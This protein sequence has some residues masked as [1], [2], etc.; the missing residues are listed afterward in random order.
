ML[1]SNHPK[2]PADVRELS[3]VHAASRQH[4]ALGGLHGIE[5]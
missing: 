1:Y 4:A 2:K 3:Q 5:R